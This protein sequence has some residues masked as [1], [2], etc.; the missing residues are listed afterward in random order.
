MLLKANSTWVDDHILYGA[1][2]DR[3]AAK[4]KSLLRHGTYRRID[5]TH[6]THLDK[7]TEFTRILERFFLADHA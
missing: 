4:A 1:M 6:V 7:P 2:S 3:D 5:A